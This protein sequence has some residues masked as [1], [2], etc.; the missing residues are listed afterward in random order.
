MAIAMSQV[1]P[2]PVAS[3]KAKTAEVPGREVLHAVAVQLADIATDLT[4]AF[5][6]GR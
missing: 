6:G 3:L 1:F 2:E 4:P 5:H